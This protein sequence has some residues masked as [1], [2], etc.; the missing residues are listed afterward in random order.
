MA[1]DHFNKATEVAKKI[2]A[3]GTLGM[4]YLDLGLLHNLKRRTAKA[5][6]YI[7]KSIQIFEQCESEIYLKQAKEALASLK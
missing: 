4:A 5:R 3:T 6:E 2:G 1:E 7:S